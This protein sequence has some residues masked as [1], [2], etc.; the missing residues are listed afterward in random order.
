MAQ[1]VENASS[2]TSEQTQASQSE[3]TGANTQATAQ[4][5]AD[6]AARGAQA[7]AD[8]AARGAQA[9]APANAPANA[10]ASKQPTPRARRQTKS[11]PVHAHI[12]QK[13]ET[14]QIILKIVS[15]LLLLVICGLGAFMIGD[16]DYHATVVGWVPFISLICAIVLAFIYL[17][18]LKNGLEISE[19]AAIGSCKK[20][21]DVVVATTFKN[22]R[23]LFYFCIKVLI[24]I[25]DSLG[26]PL[27]TINTT[28]ALSPKAKYTME[29]KVRFDH[30]GTYNAGVYE[31]TI[32]D[33][34]RLFTS[35]IPCSKQTQVFVTPRTVPI[36]R[37]TYSNDASLESQR[38]HQAT[39]SDSLD[40]AYVRE[41]VPGDPLKTIHWK[42]SARSE[43][44]MTRLFE[45]HNN[46]G[47]AIL[48]DFYAES[49]NTEALMSM[50]DA[51][52]ESAFSLANYSKEQGMDTEIHFVN[53]YG[54]RCKRLSWGGVDAQNIVEELPLM[55]K[56]AV[57]SNETLELMR[58]IIL[59][60]NGQNNLVVCSADLSSEMVSLLI[61]A[62]GR[63]RN[64][65][66]IA[67]LPPGLIGREREDY[68]ACLGRLS[69]ANI[70]YVALEVADE[71]GEVNV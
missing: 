7:N 3:Q 27:T 68:C 16:S 48:M 46:P 2:K 69:T 42:I 29:F 12:R 47:V 66:F 65:I 35:H 45:V 25:S 67:A 51:V 9:N 53:K 5:N 56:D 61:E 64:P 32:C 14:R 20:G 15:V 41:Y 17:C 30:V 60:Q 54:E 38:A 6:A 39:L 18:L 50:F 13:G 24:Y 8:A 58:S 43:N 52:V 55:K 31:V 19:S 57:H 22:N 36:K 44:Y 11:Q 49:E 26:R 21:E 23:I 37:I 34:L 62:K 28:L 59:S 1:S 70:G 4:A 40:Y 63:K 33:F 10:R 71:L